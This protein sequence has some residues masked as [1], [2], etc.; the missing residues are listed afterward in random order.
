MYCFFQLVCLFASL[1]LFCQE[2]HSFSDLE[3]PTRFHVKQ[4][5]KQRFFRIM[6]G[7]KY[8]GAAV[9]S[10]YGV[11]DFYNDHNE[12]KWCNVFDTLFDS[13]SNHIAYMTQ[14]SDIMAAENRKLWF[15]ERRKID[16]P[17]TQ[18]SVFTSPSRYAHDDR[19]RPGKEK[20]F[21]TFEA[22]RNSNFFV[23]RNAETGLAVATAT[24]NWVP[25]SESY[26]A[27][28]GRHVQEW[29]VTI[30]DRSLLQ[31]TKAPNILLI[32]T[33]LKHS[34]KHLDGTNRVNYLEKP[35]AIE[36]ELL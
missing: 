13:E 9:S 25:I 16:P 22:E 31:R 32:W 6:D 24:W 17:P 33:L 14:A 20:L 34:Q 29:E 2:E 30:T 15:W 11:F 8:L 3:C 5:K 18:I 36:K 7:S 21:L 4:D 35:P 26:F 19:G 27:S 23:F 12:K 28:W 1:S 10:S